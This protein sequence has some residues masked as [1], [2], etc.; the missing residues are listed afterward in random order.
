M[1]ARGRYCQSSY[2]R[3][4]RVLYRQLSVC[5]LAL[6]AAPFIKERLQ[7]VAALFH[8]HAS[9]DVNA[10][11]ESLQREHI[12]DASCSAGAWVP[13]A[14]YQPFHARVHYGRCTHNAR[15]QRHVQ[16]RVG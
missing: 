5:T 11:V 4:G 6:S 13:R 15:L 10:M 1:A 14:K 2:P 3:P 7:A 8:E 16:C 12:D 9:E